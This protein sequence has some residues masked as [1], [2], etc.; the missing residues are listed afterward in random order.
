MNDLR[1]TECHISGKLS[2]W[3]SVKHSSAAF[4]NQGL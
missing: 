4:E 3:Q 2:H 1:K